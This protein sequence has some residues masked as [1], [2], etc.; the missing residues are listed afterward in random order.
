M[1]S[2]CHHVWSQRLSQTHVHS[3]T[4][5]CTVRVQVAC[6]AWERT[7]D[8]VALYKASAAVHQSMGSVCILRRPPNS[9]LTKRSVGKGVALLVGCITLSSGRGAGK[10]SGRCGASGEP[11]SAP[12]ACCASVN[13]GTSTPGAGERKI[14]SEGSPAVRVGGIGSWRGDTHGKIGVIGH[15]VGE[16]PSSSGSKTLSDGSGK[17]RCSAAGVIGHHA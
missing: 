8:A 5:G 3:V 16:R 7:V 15:K 4:K 10:A 11:R 14:H 1:R 6:A 2:Q 12:K 17:A 9:T 13:D